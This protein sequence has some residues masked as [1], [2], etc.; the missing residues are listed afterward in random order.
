MKL[1]TNCSLLAIPLLTVLMLT[2]VPLAGAKRHPRRDDPKSYSM[3]EGSG[4][5]VMAL[6]AGVLGGAL[7]LSRRKR[8]VTAA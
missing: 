4:G 8:R 5:A 1:H 6:A 7:F 3:P 2:S